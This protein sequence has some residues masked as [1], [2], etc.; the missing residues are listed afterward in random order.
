MSVRN[1]GTWVEARTNEDLVMMA[2][3]PRHGE[4]SLTLYIPLHARRL[5]V[6]A[7]LP[8]FQSVPASCFRR[9]DSNKCTW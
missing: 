8:S 3:V 5:S 6:S 9:R 7:I 4:C 1:E 2:I